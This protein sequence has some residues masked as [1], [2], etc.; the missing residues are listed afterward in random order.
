MDLVAFKGFDLVGISGL[1][2]MVGLLMG[3]V[4]GN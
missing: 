2:S 3:M 4:A 1:V